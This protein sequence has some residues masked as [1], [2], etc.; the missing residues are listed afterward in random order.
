MNSLYGSKV[1]RQVYTQFYFLRHSLDIVLVNP[2]VKHE[3]LECPWRVWRA[4]LR[5]KFKC[6]INRLNPLKK[7]KTDTPAPFEVFVDGDLVHS[8]MAGDGFVDSMHKFNH[9]VR[10][11]EDSLEGNSHILFLI[12]LKFL[13][14]RNKPEK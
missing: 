6:P 14:N 4:P 7:P 8:R 3:P 2:Y 12:F 11:V 9:I 1:W 10:K 13:E 5:H